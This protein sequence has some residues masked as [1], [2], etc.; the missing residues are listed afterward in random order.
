VKI[1]GF[2]VVAEM[3][4]NQTQ[5]TFRDAVGEENGPNNRGRFPAA[6]LV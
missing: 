6:R 3:V 1:F 5:E 2:Q 4:E